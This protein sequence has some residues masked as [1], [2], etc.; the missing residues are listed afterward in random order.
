[1][2]P[3]LHLVFTLGIAMLTP[4]AMH[5]ASAQSIAQTEPSGS[6]SLN[7]APPD[8]HKDLQ[9]P[10][11]KKDEGL[12][13]DRDESPACRQLRLK[14][15]RARDTS[16]AATAD[17]YPETSMRD[18]RNP[19][20]YRQPPAPGLSVNALSPGSNIAYSKRAKLEDRYLRECR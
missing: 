8:I 11:E 4:L 7:L 2:K 6:T 3:H 17:A 5:G 15:E 16:P 13:P 10:A 18:G 19:Y 20:A 9:L 12:N 1:M 14:I